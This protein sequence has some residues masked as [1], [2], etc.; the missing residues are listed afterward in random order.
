MTASLG[1]SQKFRNKGFRRE[2]AGLIITPVQEIART[3]RGN[4]ERTI[5]FSG[6]TGILMG[7]IEFF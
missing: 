1:E 2:K 3:A 5:G 4:A 6:S 7:I